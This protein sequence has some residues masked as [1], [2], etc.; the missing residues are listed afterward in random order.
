MEEVPKIDLRSLRYVV[1]IANCGSVARAA[2]RLGLTQPALSRSVRVLEQALGVRLFDRSREGSVTTA[3]GRLLIERGRALL[4]ESGALERE[5]LL[6]SGVETG[7]LTVGV[8]TYPAR[9]SVGEAAG[10]LIA[11]HPRLELRIVVADWPELIRRVMDEELDLA[12]CECEAIEKDDRLVIE[13]LPEHAGCLFVRAGHPLAGAA[14]LDL[15][16]A[17]QYPLTISSLP[18]RSAALSRAPRADRD[19]VP[20]QVHVDTFELM[21]QIVLASDAIGAAV[22]S[23]IEDDLRSGRLVLLPLR[24]P[25][26]A[27]HYGFVRRAR[28]S[29]SPSAEAFV[30][31]VR[32]VEAGLAPPPPGRRPGRRR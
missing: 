8:G 3:H 24:L 13:P 11:L 32:E 4:A 15:A 19:T 28:R 21:R 26:L 7:R 14:S 2:A 9:I 1:A 12:I 23:T 17:L 25:W 5:L 10:R 31:F 27:T 6:L 29:M 30:R 16:A 22:P 20:P 18:S